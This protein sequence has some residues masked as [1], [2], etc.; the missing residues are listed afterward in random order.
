LH[1][2]KASS[3]LKTYKKIKEDGR[4]IEVVAEQMKAAPVHNY[5]LSLSAKS[6][7]EIKSM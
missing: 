1:F 7:S 5:P 3:P 4:Q 2:L 6:E